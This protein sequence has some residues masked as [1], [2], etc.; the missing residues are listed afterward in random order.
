LETEHNL[1]R[2]GIVCVLEVDRH[3]KRGD[4]VEVRPAG[5]I[6]ATL[7]G[8]DSLQGVPFMPEML[9]YVGRRFR[10]SHRV[11]KICDTAGGSYLSRRMHGTVMLEDLRC[12][13]SAHGGCQA[14]CRL[15]WKEEWLRPTEDT[16]RPASESD[17][18]ALAQLKARANAGTRTIRELEGTPT[19]T[20]RCQATEALAA[21][22]PL[23]RFDPRQYIRELATRNVP[24]GRLLR[25]GLRAFSV[26]IQRR[27]GRLGYLP[28]PRNG[29]P[30]V[31]RE[32]IGL[33]PGDLVQVRSPE[34]IAA[35]L[36]E[37]GMTRG[38]WFDWEMLPYC[39]GTYRVRDRVER[40]IDD[41]TGELIEISS[42]CVVLDG[43]VCT[44]EH[45]SN[46]WLCPR[47]IYPYWREAW[48]RRVDHPTASDSG[49]DSEA[50]ASA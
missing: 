25:V 19:E 18:T 31:N 2:I 32:R 24:P 29:A 39:G 9:L 42:D 16:T 50:V 7:D 49:R 44:G 4:L 30:A 48:L 6:L 26:N 3:M 17:E 12:D 22:E 27:L 10:V 14:G 46:R 38:L 45:S 40:F 23:N 47:A 20:Y 13:G 41:R 15:Y 37:K 5:E 28:L 34:E 11:E 21:S 8:R 36:D 35:T 1:K 43:V 33:R